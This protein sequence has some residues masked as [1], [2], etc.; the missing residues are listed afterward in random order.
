[1]QI[2][3]LKIFIDSEVALAGADITTLPFNAVK[4]LLSNYKTGEG[5]EMFTR[6]TVPG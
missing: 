2:I 3:K 5:M 1:M 4:G 6:D